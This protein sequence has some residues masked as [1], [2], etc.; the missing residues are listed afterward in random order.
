MKPSH[1]SSQPIL[2]PS[3]AHLLPD[4]L[5]QTPIFIIIIIIIIGT[6]TTT[7]TIITLIISPLHPPLPLPQTR[8][9]RP[10]PHAPERHQIP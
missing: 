10:P 9:P 2:P 7:T 6:T 3:T 5:S 4:L 8:E 1:T